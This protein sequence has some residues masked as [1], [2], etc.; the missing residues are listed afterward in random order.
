MLSQF[1]GPQLG[2]LMTSENAEDL[3]VLTELIESGK[4]TPVIDRTYPLSEIPRPSGTW[5]KVMLAGRSSSPS[6][7]RTTTDQLTRRPKPSTPKI[8]GPKVKATRHSLL[9]P[10]HRSQQTVAGH[11]PPTE[12]REP[13][14]IKDET[15]RPPESSATAA[16]GQTG[17]ATPDH[18]VALTAH[19][20]PG[21]SRWKWLV[22]WFLA[23]P[24][25][26]VLAF[27]WPAFL[28]VTVI[29]GF[30]ILVTGVTAGERLAIGPVGS[31]GLFGLLVVITGIVLLIT[32]KYPQQL[33]AVIVGFNRWIDRV[34]AYA[35]L[36]TDNYPPFRLDQGGSEPTTPPPP[37]AGPAVPPLPEPATSRTGS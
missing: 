34:I 25:Y 19:L 14:V 5:K 1:V 31:G 28:V 8:R 26:V 24:H 27:L 4:V 2:T 20:D 17:A 3:I 10:E 18:P 15:S 16:P 7:G 22:K 29:A 23:I 32:A 30:C 33:F 36:V 21:L 37:T 11:P 12:E 13:M 35:A 9:G 6:D